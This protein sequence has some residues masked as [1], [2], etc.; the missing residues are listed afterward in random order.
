MGADPRALPVDC[1]G[2]EMDIAKS[3]IL[4]I[5]QL[6]TLISLMHSGSTIIQKNKREWEKKED[7]FDNVEKVL[8]NLL[9]D[10]TRLVAVETKVDNLSVEISRLRDG[11]DRLREEK[12]NG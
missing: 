2:V 6:A 1:S 4:V 11:V 5:L 9:S 12:H 3:W 10:S 7:R 8:S